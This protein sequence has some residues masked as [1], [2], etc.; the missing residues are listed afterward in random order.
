MGNALTVA[1][2]VNV[3]EHRMQRAIKDIGRNTPRAINVVRRRIINMLVN[4]NFLHKCNWNYLP[5]DVVVLEMAY[6]VIMII[7]SALLLKC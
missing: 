6:N 4:V 5:K 7:F 1:D 2:D 3:V